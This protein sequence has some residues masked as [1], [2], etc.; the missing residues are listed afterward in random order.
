MYDGSFANIFYDDVRLPADALLGEV[1][2]GWKVLTSALATERGLIGGGIVLKVAHLF[3]LLCHHIKLAH[4]DG[5]P[6]AA[7]RVVRERIATLAAEIEVGRQ[8]MMHCAALAAEGITPPEYGA[9]SK[10]FSGELMERFGEAALEILGMQATLSQEAEDNLADG[11]FEQ[12]LR[13]SLMWVISIGTNEIQRSLIAQR[14]L[15]LPR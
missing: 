14:A 7:D 5:K 13:H 6:L 3:E 1:N 15:G 9:I 4:L 8:L 11:R 12:G 2:G 10:V